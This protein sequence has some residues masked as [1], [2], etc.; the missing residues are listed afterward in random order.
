MADN[1]ESTA[2]PNLRRR[3]SLSDIRAANPDLALSGNI[4]SATFNTPHSFVYRKGGDWVC[5]YSLRFDSL[6]GYPVSAAG[7]G[8]L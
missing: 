1:N 2:A 4:I 5:N 8:S 6:P 7:V 3:E